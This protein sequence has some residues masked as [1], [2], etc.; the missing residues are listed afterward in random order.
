LGLRQDASRWPDRLV[1]AIGNAGRRID[2]CAAAAHTP[3]S[4]RCFIEQRR[5]EQRRIRRYSIDIVRCFSDERKLG[6]RKLRV[7]RT[8]LVEFGRYVE[9]S[10]SGRRPGFGSIQRTASVV[11]KQPRED[12]SDASSIPDPA[13]GANF[14]LALGCGLRRGAVCALRWGGLDFERGSLHVWEALHPDG[15]FAA[16]KTERSRRTIALPGSASGA[17]SKQNATRLAS[18]QL[19]GDQGSIFADELGNQWKPASSATLSGRS[20]SEPA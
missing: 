15:T 11:G 12:G 18:G 3:R 6:R 5:I 19:Y 10:R 9:F 8:R 20:R 17:Q 2:L 13:L 4:T 14:W 16:P 1:F 7:D